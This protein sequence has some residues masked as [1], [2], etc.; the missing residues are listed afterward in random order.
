M[1]CTLHFKHCGLTSVLCLDA[2]LPEVKDALCLCLPVGLHPL[3]DA[4]VQPLDF[5]VLADITGKGQLSAIS[6]GRVS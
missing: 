3:P 2:L 1:C 4:F 6:R 5:V